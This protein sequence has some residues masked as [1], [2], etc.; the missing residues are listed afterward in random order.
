MN[1]KLLDTLHRIP[2]DPAAV[3]D[4]YRRLFESRF[5]VLTQRPAGKIEQMQFLTYPT[6]D[7]SREL[8]V[9]TARKR[10]V[11]TGLSGQVAEAEVQEVKGPKLWARVLQ[12]LETDDCFVAVD[13]GEKHGIRLTKQMILGMVN[14][15]ATK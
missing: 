2:S 3:V 10:E 1:E 6:E 12:L 5:F 8:P 13:P 15:H 11:L 9:F 4:L 14:L 7:G